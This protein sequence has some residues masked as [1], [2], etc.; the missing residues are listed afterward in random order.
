MIGGHGGNIYDLARRL[1]CRPEDIDDLSS[2]V[3]PLGPPPGLLEFL[4]GRLSAVTALPEVDNRGIQEQAAAWFGVPASRVLAAGG[5]TQFIYGIPRALGSR[6]SLIVG[7]TYADYADACRL[8]GIRPDF[9]LCAEAQGFRPDPVRLEEEIRTTGADLAFICNPNNP[10]GVLVP[11]EVIR[12]LCRRNP[13]V[14]FVVDESYLPFVQEGERHSLV[15]DGLDNLLV[16]V[17][18]SKIFRISGLRLGFLVAAPAV[19]A[20]VGRQLLPWSVNSL[21]QAAVGWLAG[22]KGMLAGF[23]AETRDYLERERNGFQAGLQHAGDLKIHPG[24]ASFLLVRLP[25]GVT[26]GEAWSR[27]ADERILIRDCSNFA[28]LS[29]R[30]IRISP[31]APEV[32]R[33]A[34]RILESLSAGPGV[35]QA[36]GPEVHEAPGPE[37]HEAH[38]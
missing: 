2:N 36:P 15:H 19:A 13:R 25:P 10:T 12:G 38:G 6:R 9:Y 22:A 34:A 29:D 11:A 26:A 7:P 4:A 21:G 3:N 8:N 24:T 1:G 20:E 5:T 33:R 27:F 23:V 32:N 14:R 31:K 30:F 35:R 37:V 18:V 17:S 28:G 16:L